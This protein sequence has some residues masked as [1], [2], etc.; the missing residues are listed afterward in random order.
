M[1]ALFDKLLELS[2]TIYVVF[3]KIFFFFA[4]NFAQLRAQYVNAGLNLPV[5][6]G[7]IPLGSF[8]YDVF[9]NPL[10]NMFPDM[11]IFFF[12]FAEGLILV[13]ALGIWKF[14][15]GIIFS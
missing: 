11:T 13:L 12:L 2:Q 5:D 4:T 9:V 10:A 14:F 1:T 6:E 7:G 15:K 8:L 3:S